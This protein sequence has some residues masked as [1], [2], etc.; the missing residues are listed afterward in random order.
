MTCNN[1]KGLGKIIKADC[2]SGQFVIKDCSCKLIKRYHCNDT[3]A[4][5]EVSEVISGVMSVLEDYNNKKYR[6]I[7]NQH[8]FESDLKEGIIN[9]LPLE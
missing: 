9:L 8:L 1:C 4:L 2:K 6:R 3:G 7:I 5:L